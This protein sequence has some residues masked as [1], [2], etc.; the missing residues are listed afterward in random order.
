MRSGTYVQI[1]AIILGAVLVTAVAVTSESKLPLSEDLVPPVRSVKPDPLHAALARCA[2]LGASA[3][4]DTNCQRAWVLNREHFLGLSPTDDAADSAS[5][6]A[7]SDNV[8]DIQNIMSAAANG[9]DASAPP[10][11]QPSQKGH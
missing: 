6:S 11:S 3:E 8:L 4:N 1:G 9:A 2:T 10:P 7:D 5:S